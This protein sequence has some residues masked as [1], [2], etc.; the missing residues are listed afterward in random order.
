MLKLNTLAIK[1]SGRVFW[2]V[3]GNHHCGP[4]EEMTPNGMPVEYSMEVVCKPHLDERG[5]LFDQAM[6]GKWLERIASK[7]T[8]KSCEELVIHVAELFMAKAAKDVPK[9]QI[10]GFKLTLSPAPH[11]ASITAAFG[12][13][14]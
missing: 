8:A 4:R 2:N 9:C 12:T 1:R 14:E 3:Y 13:L 5:F 7:P 11:R 10:V 6:V